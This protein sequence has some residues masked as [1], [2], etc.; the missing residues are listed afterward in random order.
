MITLDTSVLSLAFR[1]RSTAQEPHSSVQSLKKLIVD[2]ENLWIP[3]IV[4]QELLSGLRTDEQVA[5]LG[6]ILSGF[7]V[8]LASREHHID[9]VQIATARRRA[10]VTVTAVDCLIA[11][12]TIAAGAELLTADRD[13]NHMTSHCG[14]RLYG[15][16]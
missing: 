14:L 15:P 16:E 3:G 7:P 1:R 11:A 13:F 5:R 4:L 9:A 2:D 12:Q 8:L 10:G 6:T